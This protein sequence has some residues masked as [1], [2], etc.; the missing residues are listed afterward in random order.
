[1]TTSDAATSGAAEATVASQ[2]A[3]L[4]ED[5]AVAAFLSKLEAAEKPA[6]DE[7]DKKKA[8]EAD[9]DETDEDDTEEA[10]KDE[11]ADE[12]DEDEEPSTREASDDDKVSIKVGDEVKNVTVKELKRLFGQEAALTRKSQEVAEARKAAEQGYA[13]VDGAYAR[14][15]Q[16]AQARLEPFMKMD[17]LTLGKTLP[18]DRVEALR[19]EARAAAEHYKFINEEVAQFAKQAE[20]VQAEI[21]LSEAR[22]AAAFL[23]EAIPDYSIDTHRAMRDFAVENGLS[24]SEFDGLTHGPALALIH[25]AMKATREVAEARAKIEK[26]RSKLAKAPKN[27]NPAGKDNTGSEGKNAALSRLR[28]SGSEDDAIAA[29]TAMLTRDPE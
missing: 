16:Q 26:L 14:L 28:K 22:Q 1:M 15:K 10:A 11:D 24:V 12:E 3:P 13:V 20:A 5:D 21:K 18:P 7:E 29:F 19:N 9:S 4:S 27:V 2:T 23:R 6:E 8:P 17:F 25:K